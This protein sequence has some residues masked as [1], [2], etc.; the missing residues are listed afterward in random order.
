MKTDICPGCRTRKVQKH[1]NAKWCKPCALDRRKRPRSTL[2]SKEI[3]WCESQIG[4][5]SA[6]Q[7]AERLGT[8]LSN[9]KRAFRGKSLWFHNGKYI[10]QP[11]VVR[12]VIRYYEKHGKQATI[13][14]FP[15]I[16]VKSIVDRPEYYGIKRT[17]RQKRWTEDQIA[18][19]ARMAGV[20]SQEAQAKYF[21]RPRAFAGSITS[22]WSKTFKMSGGC[23]NGLSHHVAKELVTEKCPFIRTK[24]WQQRKKTGEYGRMLYLWVDMEKHLKNDVPEF[25][26]EAIRTMADFQRWL[27]QTKNP[28]R[29]ILKMI[30][31]REV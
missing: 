19:L 17:Y 29:K 8:S 14:K 28:R 12:S 1:H 9:V 21:K 30:E 2:S 11:D 16:N 23:I 4:K 27:H 20:I 6:P 7:M 15:N 3:A 24:F 31:E 5:L 25:I 10:N 18:E 13:K 22:V 26:V